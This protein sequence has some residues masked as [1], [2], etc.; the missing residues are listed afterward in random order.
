MYEFIFFLFR[1]PLFAKPF[2]P[3]RNKVCWILFIDGIY[4][5]ILVI[6]FDLF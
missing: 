2:T 3:V 1:F 4:L 5:F 6:L